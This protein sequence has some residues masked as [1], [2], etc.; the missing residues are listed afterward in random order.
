ML[1]AMLGLM[2][3]VVLGCC[4]V[5]VCSARNLFGR[6]SRVAPPGMSEPLL[7]T[8]SPPRDSLLTREMVRDTARLAEHIVMN[9]LD[10]DFWGAPSRG[11]G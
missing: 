9:D 3:N 6:R 11:A 4:L 7:S 8:A 2:K 1:F 10:P 5:A